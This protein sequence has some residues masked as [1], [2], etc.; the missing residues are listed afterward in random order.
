MSLAEMRK[1]IKSPDVTDEQLLA[2][3][4]LMIDVAF[5]LLDDGAQK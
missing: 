3:R 5:M 4:D 2:L 1:Y